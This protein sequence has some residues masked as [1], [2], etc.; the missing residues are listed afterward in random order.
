[1]ATLHDSKLE[2]IV[3][4]NTMERSEVRKSKSKVRSYLKRCKDA[5]YGHQNDETCNITVHED[6]PH[7]SSSSTTSWYLTEVDSNDSINAIEM[8]LP[9]ALQT[10]QA[11][12]EQEAIDNEIKCISMTEIVPVVESQ[13]NK[14]RCKNIEILIEVMCGSQSQFMKRLM[15]CKGN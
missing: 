3:I 9:K 4:N 13:V 12:D 15:L 1:V 7:A 10:N 5:I 11:C 14:V 8:Q 6:I 2:E